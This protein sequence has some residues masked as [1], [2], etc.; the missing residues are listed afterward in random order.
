MGPGSRRL[1]CVV[2]PAAL[3]LAAASAADPTV[4]AERGGAGGDAAVT[5]EAWAGELVRALGLADALPEQPAARD[6][7]TLL[8]AEQAELATDGSG[9]RGPVEG[10]FRIAVDVE[11]PD[12]P[13]EPL[14]R[15]VR[16]PA[17]ALYQL[18][19]EGAG[20]QRWVVDQRPVG[21]LDLSA[22]GVAHA[23]KIVPLRVGPHELSGYLL[24][25]ARVDRIE[26]VA[27]RP[28]CVA[29]APGWREGR[30]LTWGDW[31]RT[32]VRT[33]GF[34]R[35]LP[36]ERESEIRIEAED[37]ERATAGGGRTSRPLRQPASAR[38]WAMA[39]SSPSE[40][41]WRFRLEQPGVAS[42]H[43]RTHGAAEQI[44][45]VDG[46]YGVTLRPES[47]RGDFTWNH[48]LTL[49]L[50][51]GEH[52]VRALV[53]RGS[54]VDEIRIVPHRS[55]DAEYVAAVERA[56]F[57][58]GAPDAVV[59]RDRVQRTLAEPYFRELAAGFRRRMAG[60]ATDRSLALF[61]TEL[62]RLWT[63]PLSPVLPAD[64]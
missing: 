61:D 34:E 22:L 53:A 31:S 50:P 3:L 44:W 46:R 21:H 64:L 11:R 24:P 4:L 55:S 58:G 15:V 42:F 30:A 48:V 40:F 23:P 32:L 37:F 18:R 10:P 41:T 8:C 54:G 28:L 60:D 52:A 7:F 35:R 38:A 20:R 16:V 43:A 47:E 5:Q 29:P 13:G 17:T 39:M 2:A 57:G 12:A 59:P 51:A 6:L 62:E 26:L 25:G 56:G 27:Y 9:R 19:I 49:S 33:F 45:S 1:A 36:E 63:R 14:R